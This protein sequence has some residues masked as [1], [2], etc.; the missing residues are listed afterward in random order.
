MQLDEAG[1]FIYT[2]KV[3]NSQT[4]KSGNEV[5]DAKMSVDVE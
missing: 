5:Y 1:V 2:E 4:S 3:P